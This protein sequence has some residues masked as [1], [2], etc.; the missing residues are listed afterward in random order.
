MPSTRSLATL[1][2]LDRVEEHTWS[3]PTGGLRL[4]RLFGGQLVAQSLVA[5]TSD[6]PDS[7]GTPRS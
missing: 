2:T 5:A 4:P 7:R 1:F 3:G 6:V